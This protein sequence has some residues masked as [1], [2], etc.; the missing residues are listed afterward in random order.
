MTEPTT[1]PA[2]DPVE[3]RDAWLESR[4]KG[5][6]GSDVAALFGVSPW[7]SPYTLYLDKLGQLPKRDDT[8]VLQ[9][10]HE[11]EPLTRRL[12]MDATGREVVECQ[13]QMQHP[14]H[15]WMLATRDGIIAPCD[16]HSGEG[17]FEGKTTNPY[18]KGAWDDGPPLYY[19][20]QATHYMV[21]S[22]CSWASIAVLVL[23][24]KE[25]LL[26][27]DIELDTEFA[28][29]MV[30]AERKFWVEHVEAQIPPEVDGHAAT[31]RVLKEL[32]PRDSGLI[33]ELDES[34][35]EWRD[36]LVIAKASIKELGARKDELEN[37]VRAAMEDAT[38]AVLPDGSGWSHKTSS[39]DEYVVKASTRRTLRSMSTKSMDRAKRAAEK[40]MEGM[41]IE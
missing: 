24:E 1:Q 13:Q 16:D 20:L 18:S 4:R 17:V 3:E 35:M 6:G 33:V 11:L 27:A 10:G 22:G 38:F 9:V 25:P 41:T 23:G 32:H 21:V 26:W 28:D 14:E 15:P 5:I 12:Y 2:L 30:E 29:M 19:V 8:A 36:E 7:A 37:K 39:R 31:T 34:A 40:T